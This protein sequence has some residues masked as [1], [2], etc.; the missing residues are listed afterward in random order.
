MI[1]S[2]ER[3]ELLAEILNQLGLALSNIESQ[4]NLY[5]ERCSTIG[6]NVQVTMPNGEKI[7]DLAIGI[8]EDG[9][10]LLKSREISVGDII[11]LR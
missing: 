9:S 2:V 8:S 10:L 1:A 3:S 6:K 4:K 7:E 11:H 5:R